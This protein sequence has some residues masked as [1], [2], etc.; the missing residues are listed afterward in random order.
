MATYFVGKGGSDASDGTSWANR[1][2]TLNGAEDI[3]VA[4]GDTVY[5][6]PGVYREVLTCDVSGSS[7]S[8]ITYI[9]DWT[10]EN[11]DGVG[12]IVRITG[13]DDDQT[14]TR[15][16][17]LQV[18]SIDYRTFRGLMI[19][20]TDSTTVDADGTDNLILED[21]FLCGTDYIYLDIGTATNY[22]VRRCVFV[23]GKQYSGIAYDYA[24]TDTDT[25]GVFENCLIYGAKYGL[26]VG[27]G[28]HSVYNCTFIGGGDFVRVHTSLPTGYTA[29]TVENCLFYSSTG[30]ALNAQATG[31]IVED[32]NLFYQN[33]TDRTNV[34]T[35]ANSV[36]YAPIFAPFLLLAGYRVTPPIVG[37]LSHWAAVV[38]T[39]DS[40]NGPS[41]DLFGYGRP[42]ASGKQT[43]GPLALNE[44]TRET[45]TTHNTSTASLG[46]PDAGRVQF[47]IPTDGTQIT[48]S[49]YVY[50]EAN[51][52]GTN[53]QMIVRQPGESADTTTDAG[54]SGSW[55]QLST[56]LT[57]STDTDYVIVELASNNTATSGSYVV[58]FDDLEVN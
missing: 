36:N 2:L 14:F 30:S 37:A 52:S 25:G 50:R 21:C 26:N 10:G 15:N 9:G 19:D 47:R 18:A 11:T 39:S 48:I 31:E 45:G 29:I 5:V 34:S 27:T 54:S 12:G 42:S 43:W 57:P 7:G 24:N 28:G 23:G 35:G 49:V 56:T 4:A 46:L 16:H 22:T 55:N 6:G 51:Y 40:G 8:P 13:S 44:V 20:T 3:P 38:R 32:Y 53:P 1:K 33:G 41:D 58:Y 17:A